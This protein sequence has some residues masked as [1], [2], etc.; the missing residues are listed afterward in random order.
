MYTGQ[1]NHS[2]LSGVPLGWG[3]DRAI[4]RF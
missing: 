1:W 4:L 3:L 2:D